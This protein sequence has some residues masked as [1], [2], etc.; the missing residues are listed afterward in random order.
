MVIKGGILLALGYN[1]TRHT[2]DID[3]S[4]FEMPE[5]NGEKAVINE[6]G[7]KLASAVAELD[8]GIDCRIQS[9]RMNP[10]RDDATFPTLEIR[11]GYA[12]RNNTS[13]LKRLING[14]S[15][16]I[17]KIDYSYNELNIANE[18]LEICEGGSILSYS[19]PDLVGEKYRA[20]IQQKDRNR[21]RR[22]DPYDIYWLFK[23]GFL[24]GK[25]LKPRILLSLIRKSAS[26]NLSVDENSL[27]DKE[28]RLR[29]KKEYDLLADEIDEELPTFDLVFDTVNEFYKAL[30]WRDRD[31]LK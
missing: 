14:N 23:N 5:A 6:L 16:D 30:P 20:V 25:R 31:K 26:R 22:Q 10:K 1:N 28:I 12:N 18:A 27:D 17:V 29:A 3:F 24:E 11:I 21:F 13:K 7:K 9:S 19:L 8:Y 2:K 15:S 4:T